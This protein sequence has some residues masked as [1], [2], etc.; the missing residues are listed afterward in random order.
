MIL[1]LCMTVGILSACTGD[2]GATGAQGEQGEKGEKGDPG[3]D[4]GD[5]TSFYDFLKAWGSDTGEVSCS[6]PI[7]TGDA[8][9]PGPAMLNPDLMNGAPNPTV[10]F[11]ANCPNALFRELDGDGTAPDDSIMVHGMNV[12]A[13]DDAEI[14][15]VATGRLTGANALVTETETEATATKRA[16][17][18]EET[19][20]FVG[21]V[22]LADMSTSGGNDE[23]FER[24]ELYHDCGVGTPPSDI[25][26][27]WRAVK[28][29][30]T[31]TQYSAPGVPIAAGSP[32]APA[33]SNTT[34]VCVK[35]DSMPGVVKCF[36]EEDGPLATGD[37]REQIALYD[38][39]G[40]T[41]VAPMAMDDGT[42]AAPGASAN[43]TNANV[44][45][46]FGTGTEAPQILSADDLGKTCWLFEEG[47]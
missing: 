26:G 44:D 21:G 7:L 35:L 4:A 42:L 5:A 43:G 3:E 12:T 38:E 14:V 39:T 47:G 28:I 19:K 30:K 17:L 32:G 10:A 22:I 46:L 11:A 25:R 2:D 36:I 16:A 41:P 18:T 20:S 45:N 9:F 1:L 15:F 6:D 40:A 24:H 8:A 34:K 13:T 23:V 29:T 33:T 27:E 31:V 37:V